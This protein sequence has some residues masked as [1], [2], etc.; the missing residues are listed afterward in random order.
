MLLGALQWIAVGVAAVLG[1]VFP[2]YLKFRG[3]KGVATSLGM[4]LGLWPV[5][6]LAGVGAAGVWWV[7]LKLTRY[8]SVASILAAVAVPLLAAIV[9][10][11]WGTPLQPLLVYVGVSTLLAGLV[12]FR[13]RAN[14]QRLRA[15][16]ELKIA[17]R[18]V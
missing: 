4:V 2:I 10:G 18:K 15:G 7:T 12:I 5:L 14:L 16:T 1:H 3:G 8:V 13:H 9:G 6:T 11:L 17:S